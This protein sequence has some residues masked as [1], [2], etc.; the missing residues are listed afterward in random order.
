MLDSY[1][2][3]LFNRLKKTF[4]SSLVT[5]K[6]SILYSNPKETLGKGNNTTYI[7]SIVSCCCLCCIIAIG[8]ILYKLENDKKQEKK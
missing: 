5:N 1:D 4:S 8:L 7:V 3:K 6:N 2:A